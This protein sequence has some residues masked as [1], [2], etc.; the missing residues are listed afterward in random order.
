[1]ARRSHPNNLYMFQQN[2]GGV[3]DGGSAWDPP[4]TWRH[5]NGGAH[6]QVLINAV[7]QSR[8]GHFFI[9]FFFKVIFFLF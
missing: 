9:V 3:K 7:L 6:V 1:M 8:Q 4:L 5:C 2:Q